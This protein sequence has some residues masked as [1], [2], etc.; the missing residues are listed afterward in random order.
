MRDHRTSERPP[1]PPSTR[2]RINW[3][4]TR[5]L[6]DVCAA[7]SASNALAPSHA[8]LDPPGYVAAATSRK[9][10]PKPRAAPTPESI[11]ALKAKKAW[12]VAFGPAKNLPMNAFMLYMSGAGVQIFSM[13]VV[14]ML[15]TNPIKAALGVQGAFAPL[16]TP[17]QP[18]ALLPQKLA[19]LGAQALCFALG[20]WKCAGMGLLPTASSD[21]LAW[22]AP[23]LPLEF[24]P[25]YS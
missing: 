22:R 25:L 11:A 17:S 5:S 4:D 2:C 9:S 15:L 12:D 3:A 7:S 10:T 23:R 24:S 1:L 6:D 14:G 8:T 16:S 20:V 18:H 19:F 21:W 13:M